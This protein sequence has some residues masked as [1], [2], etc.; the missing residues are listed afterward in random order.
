MEPAKVARRR[1]SSAAP[2]AF[3]RRERAS[4]SSA[5]SAALAASRLS[6]RARAASEGS[7]Q[8]SGSRRR[9]HS[10]S[11]ASSCAALLDLSARR[12][13]LGLSPVLRLA[14]AEEVALLA[15]CSH[16][17]LFAAG[18]PIVMAHAPAEALYIVVDGRVSVLQAVVP[19]SAV[20]SPAGRLALKEVSV[21]GCFALLG[22]SAALHGSDGYRFTIRA[23]GQVHALVV[24]MS[25][26]RSLLRAGGR[27][28]LSATDA[29]VRRCF[30]TAPSTP[31][32]SSSEPSELS[33][34]ELSG[35]AR[36]RSGCVAA[37]VV[38]GGRH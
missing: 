37:V 17:V 16:S 6:S 1:R 35:A 28:L 31:Y 33:W 4:R 21:I 24:A 15:A 7:W 32:L 3:L 25:D 38:E 9:S 29:H 26:F 11:D 18:A 5:P 12:T 19:H 13:F 27:S 36:W 10:S 8:P 2:A 23:R 30:P 14:G 20:P 34:K 22:A